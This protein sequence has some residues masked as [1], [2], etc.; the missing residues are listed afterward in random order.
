VRYALVSE[1]VR[2]KLSPAERKRIAADLAAS[3]AETPTPA[4]VL[5]LLEVAAGQRQRQLD[6]FRG[7]KTHEKTFLRFLDTIPLREFSEAELEK[8]CAYLRTLDARKPWQHCL[9]FAERRFENNPAFALSRLDFLL[10]RKSGS[11]P[12]W[13]LH[14]TLNRARAL[15]QALPREQQE[16]Y[17][18][19]LRHRQQHIE[20]TVGPAVNPMDVLGGIFD[21]FG[22]PDEFEDDEDW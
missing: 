5:A 12:P 1:S 9:N 14:E 8:L 7:Q 18:P 21:A 2:A 22:E 11:S 3:L 6:A 19:I 10:A 16:R 15:V 13:Q 17:L 20:A 4:E